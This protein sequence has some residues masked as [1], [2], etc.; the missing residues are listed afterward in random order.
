MNYPNH[1]DCE[2]DDGTEFKVYFEYDPGESQ[3]FDARA[4]VGSPG[5]PPSIEI[6]EVDFGK[7]RESVETYPQLNLD[8]IH[9]RIVDVLAE[10]DETNDAEYTEHLV[11][12][13]EEMFRFEDYR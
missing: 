5:Y 8:A 13:H 6:T 9:D 2:A 12:K 4:G 11:S 7:G 1:I 3:W 10:I